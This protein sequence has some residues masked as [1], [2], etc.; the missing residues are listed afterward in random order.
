MIDTE[1]ELPEKLKSGN[2]DHTDHLRCGGVLHGMSMQ[3]IANI[4]WTRYIEAIN[5]QY[6]EEKEVVVVPIG[7]WCGCW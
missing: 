1:V 5:T 2:D 3:K 7:V 6:R 4:A